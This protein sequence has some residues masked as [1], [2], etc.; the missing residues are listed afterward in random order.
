MAYT[1]LEY[2]QQD[3]V[4]IF[5]EII[6]Q[7]RHEGQYMHPGPEATVFAAEHGEDKTGVINTDAHL[8]SMF[9]GRSESIVIADGEMDLGEF[10]HIYFIDFDWTR[11]R[12]RTIQVQVFGE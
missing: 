12:T 10:G 11:P 9:M 8:R 7:C 2:M 3:L 5:E 6:P 1:G 4:D